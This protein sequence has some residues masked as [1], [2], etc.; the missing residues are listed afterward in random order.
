MPSSTSVAGTAATTAAVY[1]WRP[2]AYGNPDFTE[3]RATLRDAAVPDDPADACA[4]PRQSLRRPLGPARGEALA[5][6][7]A[8]GRHP[9]RLSLH[10][11]RGGWTLRAP[12]AGQAR[13]SGRR[14]S[15][16]RG[17]RLYILLSGTGASSPD[18]LR[19]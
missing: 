4:I 6:R 1:C 2:L 16:D 10:Q 9:G 12:D 5:V 14:G 11:M 3:S 8:P 13:G 19:G 7:A 18:L 17:D 15:A